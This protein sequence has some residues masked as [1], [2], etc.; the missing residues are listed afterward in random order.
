MRIRTKCALCR[1]PPPF[2]FTFSCRR[3][4][5]GALRGGCE[6]F[7]DHLHRLPDAVPP[8]LAVTSLPVRQ[9][10]APGHPPEQRLL[11]AADRLREATVR[12]DDSQDGSL[13]HRERSRRVFRR[14]REYGLVTSGGP[15]GCLRGA[16]GSRDRIG[17]GTRRCRGWGIPE[18]IFWQIWWGRSREGKG[19]ATPP[20]RQTSPPPGSSASASAPCPP[21]RHSAQAEAPQRWRRSR[22]NLAG[23]GCWGEGLGTTPRSGLR[24]YRR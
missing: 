9:E 23:L 22:V 12:Q 5:A 24:G 7:G 2:V 3:Q 14:D 8:H 6:P 21:P 16:S 4:D 10:Q 19:T 18:T 17:T 15:G 13:A 20:R 11:P 1:P